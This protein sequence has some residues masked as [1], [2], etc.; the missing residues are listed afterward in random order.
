MEK[1]KD[2]FYYNLIKIENNKKCVK[3]KSLSQMLK[4]YSKIYVDKEKEYTLEENDVEPQLIQT[5]KDQKRDK[6]H[7]TDEVNDPISLLD[8]DIQISLESLID[9]LNKNNSPGLV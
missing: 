1:R 7:Q 2:M 4:S 5:I 6:C 8:L 9:N 3:N